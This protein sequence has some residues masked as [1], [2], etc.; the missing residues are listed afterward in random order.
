MA[1]IGHRCA[2][3]H[4]NTQH[5]SG[6]CTANNSKPCGRPCQMPDEAQVFPTFDVRGRRVERVIEPGGGWPSLGG[7]TFG[8]TCTCDACTA[9]YAEM[10]R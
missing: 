7:N 2:C 4:S 6:K 1:Y 8:K 9:L 3:G 5:T 10:T